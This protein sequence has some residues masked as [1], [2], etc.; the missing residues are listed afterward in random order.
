MKGSITLSR[1][2]ISMWLSIAGTTVSPTE[3]H[4]DTVRDPAAAEAL[5][6]S[7]MDLLAQGDERGACAKFQASQDLDP[8][9]STMVKLAACR[10][11]EG[12]LA[13][14]WY[15]LQQAL[16]L[17]SDTAGETDKRRQ[18]LD[19][20]TKSQLAS[21]EPRVPHLRISVKSAPTG[22]KVKRDGK[23]LPPATFGEALPVNPGA[24]ETFAEAS[25]FSAD[26]HTVTVGEGQTVDIVIELAP[27]PT[28]AAAPSTPRAPDAAPALP[29]ESSH[30]PGGQRTAGF[31]VGGIGIGALALGGVLGIVTLVDEG[32]AAP[33]AGG[34]SARDVAR[35]TQT[36]GLVFAGVGAAAIGGSIVLLVT[37]PKK[38]PGLALHAGLNGVSLT[39]VW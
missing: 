5:F 21:L 29:P 37:Q 26:R 13:Q 9:V 39:G 25:G 20:F 14:A 2:M 28:A 10:E 12:K 1:V 15:L 31:V 24:H 17:N 6:K 32:R 11:H 34:N 18:E 30:A 16:K 4:A 8:A 22:V 35:A 38:V 27:H 36:A 33:G 3:V 7:G 19:A 23:E